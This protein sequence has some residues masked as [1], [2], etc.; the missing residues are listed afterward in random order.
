MSDDS[1]WNLRRALRLPPT[2][3]RVRA[4]VD[5]ELEF[6]IEG[7]AAELIAAGMPRDEAFAEA[8]RRFGDYARIEREVE[9]LS[10]RR[11]RREAFGDWMEG[12][13][14][15]LRYAIRSLTRQPLFAGAV[16]LTLTLGIGATAAIFHAVDRVVLHPLPYPNADRIVYLGQ[17]WGKGSPIGAVSAGRFQF[18]HDNSRSFESLGTSQTFSAQLGADDAAGSIDG[19]KVTPEF[20]RTVGATPEFGRPLAPRDYEPGAP[21]TAM[22]GHSF[23]MARYGGNHDVIGKTIHLDST[24]YAIVGVLP[25]SFEIAELTHSPAVVV[26]L[27]FSD[28]VLASPGA[29]FTAIGRLRAGVTATQLGQDMTSVFA[30][31][32]R[33]FPERVEKNDYGIVALRYQDI[34]VSDIIS[35]LWI[36]FGA[37]LF[38]LLLACAN[39]ANLA[40]A[41]AL[42]RQREFAVRSALGAGR[43]RLIRYIV[44][45]MLV[46]GVASAVTATVAS[47]ATVRGLTGLANGALLH[48]AQ[49]RLDPRVVVWTAAT[50][51]IASIIIALVVAG[52]TTR[53]DVTRSLSS[54][55]R[56]GGLGGSA[57]LRGLRGF[58]VS[59]EAALAM[60]LLAGAGLLITSFANVLRV[61]GGFRRE[62]IYTASIAHPPSDYSNSVTMHQFEDRVLSSLRATPG[63]IGAGA[64]QTLPLVRGWN[65]PTTVEGHDDLTEGASEFRAASPGYFSTMGIRLVGGRDFSALDVAASPRV[66]L[67]SEAYAKR[68]FD[69]ATPIGRRILIGCF[70]GCPR[71]TTR[72]AYEIVGVVAD[73]RDASLEEKRLRHTV[74]VPLAQV[75]RRML[76]VPAFVVRATDARVGATA[77]RRAVADAEPRM[78][79]PDIA[80]MTD[81]V[82]R[83][84]SWRRFSTVLMVCFAALAL[85]LTCV[86]IYGVASYSV[87]QRVQEIGVRIALGAKPGSVVALV[88]RQGVRP[89]VIGLLVGVVLALG[90]SR[91]LT[92][93]LFGVG[94][95]D[96]LS[97]AAVAAVLL[98]VAIVA[99]Y[100][101]AR[102]A[103]RV[104]PAS[105]LRV[106]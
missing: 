58:L 49:L 67:V 106:E 1:R 4:A 40:F 81:I 87:S 19:I 42:S 20:L 37:T 105:A 62:G 77:L 54:S 64:T 31:Y 51:L 35:P 93:L 72:M 55:A 78:G 85:A 5:E 104:D 34:F 97:F 16:V 59:L 90:L 26:P 89:A 60:V 57:S 91:I 24:T 43:S 52:A 39:V 53:T 70:K 86:G 68:F 11:S 33:A 10:R 69:D 75:E 2:R 15:D 71:D 13:V 65:L 8:R 94:P 84:M 98:G 79:I 27:V 29:N 22:L 66:A 25:E 28:D 103:A 102:R 17:Q 18:W 61:D 21:A 99:S 14:G 95:R 74:W 32:Q 7:R 9:Q 83:S 88:V 46:L 41:R 47:L 92:K 73:L 63:I 36:M 100:L 3:T 12:V 76:R 44:A 50:A 38:V 30:S 23:W 101:P 56:A 6:H 45:E 82:S 80:A 48:D 96:P